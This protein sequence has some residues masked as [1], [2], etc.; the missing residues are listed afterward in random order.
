MHTTPSKE[1]R[2]A[3]TTRMDEATLVILPLD[4]LASTDPD[5]MPGLCFT[6][7]YTDPY[8]DWPVAA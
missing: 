5:G 7:C 3:L 4:G 1:L 6:Y 2:S 8:G